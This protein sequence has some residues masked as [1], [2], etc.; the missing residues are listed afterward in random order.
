M[1]RITGSFPE[2]TPSV[3]ADDV[4]PP[5]KFAQQLIDAGGNS[6]TYGCSAIWTDSRTSDE[7]QD[8]YSDLR[9]D[10]D[11]LLEDLMDA[12]LNIDG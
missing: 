4:F 8:P 9:D 1:F 3:P 7:T 11:S 12:Y 5:S 2:P 6:A 10:I